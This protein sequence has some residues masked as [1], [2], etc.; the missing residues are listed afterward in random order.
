MAKNVLRQGQLITTYGPGSMVDLLDEAV[1]VASTRS[2]AMTRRTF[3][4]SRSLGWSRRF[5]DCLTYRVLHCVHRR[6]LR[7]SA[8]GFR[9]QSRSGASRTGS[10]FP[11]LVEVT[12]LVAAAVE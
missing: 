5:V 11:I 10:C 3:R 12:P 9:P 8:G 2:M 7:G 1:I 6:R 4:P